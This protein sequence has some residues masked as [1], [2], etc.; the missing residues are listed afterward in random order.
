[1]GRNQ[2][3]IVVA[4]RRIDVVAPGGLDA[5]RQIVPAMNGKVEEAFRDEGIALRLPPAVQDLP[6]DVLRQGLE[7]L[8]VGVQG[9]R[10]IRQ[11][12]GEAVS[13]VGRPRHQS[14]DEFGTIEGN[15][16]HSVSG[17]LHRLD[18]GG[19]RGRGIESDTV[20]ETR[21][22][23]RVVG[24][25]DGDPAVPGRSATEARPSGSQPRGP[26]DAVGDRPMGHDTDLGFRKTWSGGLE[27]DGAGENASIDFRE[28][29]IHRDVAGGKAACAFMPLIEG[30]AREDGLED[31]AAGAVKGR[32]TTIGTRT[33]DR[34]AG[35]VDDHRRSEG[36]QRFLD[37]DG[38]RRLLEDSG[39]RAAAG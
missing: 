12:R 5:N 17:V 28:R 4:P 6:A 21:V 16:V 18:D 36:G 1:M 13:P 8:P 32:G 2:I 29:H 34:K 39:C 22:L 35:C 3:R 14:S 7:V 38:R 9:D 37:E 25:N 27:G 10:D 24:E 23:S 31:R 15:T 33:R 20:G 30:F 26:G 19:G 11:P